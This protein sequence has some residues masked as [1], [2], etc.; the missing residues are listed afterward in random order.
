MQCENFSETEVYYIELYA[1]Q[2]QLTIDR[3]NAE[4]ISIRK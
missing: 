3:I 2:K 4:T 1:K